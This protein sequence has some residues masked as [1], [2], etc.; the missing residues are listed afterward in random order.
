MSE[1][2]YD[3]PVFNPTDDPEKIKDRYR[4]GRP[5][6]WRKLVLLD[7]KNFPDFYVAGLMIGFL[8]LEWLE[9]YYP[10]LWRA[11]GRASFLKGKAD[12]AACAEAM[13]SGSEYGPGVPHFED[14]AGDLWRVRNTDPDMFAAA[15]CNKFGRYRGLV[16]V[17]EVIKQ[18][19]ANASD[20]EPNHEIINRIFKYLNIG[21]T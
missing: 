2:T 5:R 19:A 13:T 1:N 8:G 7:N 10:L 18:G 3:C 6:K 12:A 17:G 16:L 9:P 21:E 15:M 11:D 14:I 4:R 20:L